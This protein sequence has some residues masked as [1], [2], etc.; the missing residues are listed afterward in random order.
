[1]RPPGG[2]TPEVAAT[3]ALS[4]PEGSTGDAQAAGLDSFPAVL[5]CA[6]ARATPVPGYAAETTEVAF[7]RGLGDDSAPTDANHLPSHMKSTSSGGSLASRGEVIHI[8]AGR[9]SDRTADRV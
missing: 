2:L 5:L 8:F 1:V 3:S 9:G 4:S 6:A 7:T